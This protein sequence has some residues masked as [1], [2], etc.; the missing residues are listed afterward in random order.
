VTENVAL[1][2]VLA[3]ADERAARRRAHEMLERIGLGALVRRLPDE[4]SGGQAQ[5]VAAARALVTDPRI[6]LADE[7][8]GQLDQA[9]GASLLDALL[10]ELADDAALIVATHDQSV[11][12]HLPLRWQ[13]N[14]GWLDTGVP[15]CS[16]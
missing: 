10:R 3:G 11:A 14:D 1:P 4:V 13:L 12:E 6:V 7:P 5:R 2:L 8:T 9:T 15:V 16:R